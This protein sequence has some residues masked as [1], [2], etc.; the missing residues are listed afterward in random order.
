MAKILVTGADGQL[1]R[2][3]RKMSFKYLEFKF[4]FKTS[5]ELDISNTLQIKALLDNT[6]FNSL[7]RQYSLIIIFCTFC[8]TL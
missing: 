8:G 5:K 1:G 6:N 3:F 7:A 2:T 4:T